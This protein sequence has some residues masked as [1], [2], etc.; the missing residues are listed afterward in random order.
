MRLGF[1]NKIHDTAI[2]EE[3]V[4][5]GNDNVIGA[6]TI[7]KKGTTIGNGNYIGSYC[8]IGD[9]AE[10][11]G[12]FELNAGVNIGHGNTF[13]K[14]VT[15]DRGTERVT[16]IGDE[17]TFL[18]NSH[19]GHD[20]TV[21]NKCVLTC[22]VAIGG[23]TTVNSFCNI[24]LNAST[25]PRAV[26]PEGSMLGSNSFYKGISKERFKIWVGQ[27]A[28]IKKDNTIGKERYNKYILDND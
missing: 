18:A 8:V 27:P 10:K 4:I 20:A 14:Q 16:Y 2:I 6:Y 11:I 5:L 21:M 26:M 25:H 7:I 23:F 1:N 24:G 13:T 15:I 17:N 9:F 22:N 12:C 3:G 19:V 28:K